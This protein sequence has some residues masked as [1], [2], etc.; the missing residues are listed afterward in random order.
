MQFNLFISVFRDFCKVDE[1][2]NAPKR[3]IAT[4]LAAINLPI[5]KHFVECRNTIKQM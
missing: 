5:T 1:L 3:A 4:D 2:L